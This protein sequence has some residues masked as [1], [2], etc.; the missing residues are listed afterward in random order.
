M[1]SAL[2]N[3]GRRG[4]PRRY[5]GAVIIRV[6][7]ATVPAESSGQLHVLMREQLPILR[8][9]DGLVYVKLARRLIGS[10]E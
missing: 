1:T 10:Q 8:E 4:P 7:T 6:L 3:A 9:Y 2:Q 5:A